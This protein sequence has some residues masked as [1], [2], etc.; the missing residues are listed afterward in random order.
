MVAKTDRA[1]MVFHSEENKIM[2]RWS[3]LP[4]I[5]RLLNEGFCVLREREQKPV[6]NSLSTT[7]LFVETNK[8]G[9]RVCAY[10]IFHQISPLFFSSLRVRN[11]Y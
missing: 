2:P 4:L 9:V 6:G 7:I 11:E 8:S 10:A 3:R 1:L 5:S